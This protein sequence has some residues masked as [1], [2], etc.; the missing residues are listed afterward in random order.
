MN[1]KYS[2]ELVNEYVQCMKDDYDH[3]ATPEEAQMHLASLS[4][5]FDVFARIENRCSNGD[6]G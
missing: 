5:L 3:V 4:R 6:H 1:K 2:D